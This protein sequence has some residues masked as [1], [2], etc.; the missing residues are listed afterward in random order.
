MKIKTFSYRFAEEIITHP[1]NIKIYAELMNICENAPISLYKGKSKNQKKLDVV[2]QVMNTYFRL[3]FRDFGWEEEPLATPDSFSDALR[4][5]FRKE[6]ELSNQT[7]TTQVE[8]EFGN[9]ASSYRD[10]FKFQLSF[11]YDL[12]DVCILILPTDKLAKRIDSGVASFEKTVK[13]IPSAKLSITVP[14]F[15]I[16]LDPTDEPEWDVKLVE[17][18]LKILK[19]EN[20]KVY[21]QHDEI[22]KN[23]ILSLDK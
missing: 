17:P 13:E 22:I 9:A 7:I 11:T 2:Q 15:V 14:I 5:D 12:T 18:D 20:K 6:F 23:Y 3:R 10:Y 16:G 8:V 4:G 19:R 1:N 21:Q